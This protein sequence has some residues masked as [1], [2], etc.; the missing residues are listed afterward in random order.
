M[1][2]IFIYFI[3]LTLLNSCNN[4]ENSEN[5]NLLGNDYALFKN[6]PLAQLANALE[7]GDS[8]KINTEATKKNVNLNFQEPKFG[9]TLLMLSIRNRQFENVELLLKLAANPNVVDTYRGETAVITAA[10]IP[11]SKYLDII[12]RYKGNPNSIEN[13]ATKEGDEARRS[14]LTSAIGP[15]DNSSLEKVKLLVNAGANIDYRVE[16]HTDTALSEALTNEKMDLVLY[17]LQKGANINQYIYKTVNGREVYI[18]RALRTCV[19]DLDSKEFNQ[20]LE[21]IKLLKSKGLDYNKE[22]IPD[23]ILKEIK[24]KYPE[25]WENIIKS[26]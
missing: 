13:L 7:T 4:K 24:E 14:A 23:Y 26:Y 22:P 6:T 9:S 12:L 1:K 20:K 3:I 25:D 15:L 19:F 16:G 5:K 11:E 2:K 10:K 21:V 17:L 18:L 8:L